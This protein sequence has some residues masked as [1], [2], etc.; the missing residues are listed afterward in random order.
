MAACL[1]LIVICAAHAGASV[2]L[3][4]CEMRRQGR[5]LPD[6]EAEQYLERITGPDSLYP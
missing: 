6:P 1:L 3:V 2:Y 4:A 5:S